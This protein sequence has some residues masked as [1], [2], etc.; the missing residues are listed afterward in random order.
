[1]CATWC[2]D[3]LSADANP[4]AGAANTTLQQIARTEFPAHQ[5]DINRF[6]SKSE[7]RV[8][9]NDAQPAQFCQVGEDVFG[10]TVS[11][12]RTFSRPSGAAAPLAVP[13]AARSTRR[14]RSWLTHVCVG[15]IMERESG[16]GAGRPYARR[17]RPHLSLARA[18]RCRRRRCISATSGT[19]TRNRFFPW[20]RQSHR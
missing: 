7:A 5:A 12:F 2:V 1:M 13:M 11:G 14:A 8:A 18:A 19:R 15:E 6:A 16:S 10:D 17:P 20:R 9:G 3:E 4:I